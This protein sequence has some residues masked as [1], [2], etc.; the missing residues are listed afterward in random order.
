MSNAILPAF[1]GLGWSYIK[2]PE[3]K[4]RTHETVSGMEFRTAMMSYPT[5]KF[6]LTYEVLRQSAALKEL[7]QMMDFYNSR[8]GAW[9]DFLITDP[10]D[11]SVTAEP[12]G[13][14]DGTTTQFQLIRKLYTSGFSEPVQNLNGAPA[15]YKNGVLQA[16]PAN[17]SVNSL[18]VV[19][20]VSAPPN[21][22]ALTWTG[23][24][25]FRVRFMQDLLEFDQFMYQLWT[26]KKVQLRSVKQ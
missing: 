14:G 6:T 22:H 8:R 23:S 1:P 26:L 2:S 20:F 16:T 25:Y 3:W 4:T 24:Y 19:T 13:T 17:Y 10:G 7:Q 18:G 11:S 21:G 15:I 12:F 9:D 5:W